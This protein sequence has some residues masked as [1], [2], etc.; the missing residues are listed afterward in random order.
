MAIPTRERRARAEELS[1]EEAHA[2]FD[3]VAR[4]EL[5]ISGEEFLR[6]WDSGEYE[7][8]ADQPNVARVAMLL[9]FGR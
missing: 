8:R 2:I 6:R 4:E 7:G 5:S 1:P 9:P 3:R